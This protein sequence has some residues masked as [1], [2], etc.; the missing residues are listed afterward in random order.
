[1]T[2]SSDQGGGD[3]MLLTKPK[4]ATDS[5]ET[6]VS[7]PRIPGRKVEK[8]H[9]YVKRHTE[10]RPDSLV[11]SMRRRQMT[12]SQPKTSDLL[13]YAHAPAVCD[14]GKPRNSW[15]GRGFRKKQLESFCEAI[16]QS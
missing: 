5:R 13:G 14:G 12:Q 6:G 4:P 10:G 2:D 15:L 9:E 7:A 16:E 8:R 11:R 1:M 3:P